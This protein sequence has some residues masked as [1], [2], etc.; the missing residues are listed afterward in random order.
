MTTESHQVDPKEQQLGLETVLKSLRTQRN[1]AL[2]LVADLSAHIEILQ[3]RLTLAG[4]QKDKAKT[5]AE[6]YKAIAEKLATGDPLTEEMAK[7]LGI[8]PAEA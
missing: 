1:E 7:L 4:E 6:G 8:H 5:I 3:A 2:D